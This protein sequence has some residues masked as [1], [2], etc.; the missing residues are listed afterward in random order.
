MYMV[1]WCSFDGVVLLCEVCV[2]SN[3]LRELTID[4]SRSIHVI[5]DCVG[6]LRILLIL[7][8]KVCPLNGL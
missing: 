5:F 8:L 4:S 7:Q 2:P 3:G 1:A 6:V